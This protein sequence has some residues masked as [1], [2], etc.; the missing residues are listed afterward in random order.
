MLRAH[1][2]NGLWIL[3]ELKQ[4]DRRS[5][6]FSHELNRSNELEFD[7]IVDDDISLIR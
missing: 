4:F 1:R 7:D 3:V 2:P 5:T 6:G